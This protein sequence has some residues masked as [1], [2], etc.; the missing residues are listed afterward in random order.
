MCFKALFALAALSAAAVVRPSFAADC[1]AG[2]K[3]RCTGSAYCTVETCNA[4]E[5]VDHTK[6]RSYQNENDV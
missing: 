6:Y 2:T 3:G 5:C 1:C 4:S